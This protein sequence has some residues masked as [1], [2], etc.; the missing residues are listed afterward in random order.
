MGTLKVLFE[1]LTAR[2]EATNAPD[3]MEIL[4][5]LV[6]ALRLLL[7]IF[8]PLRVSLLY[9][10]LRRLSSGT[11]DSLLLALAVKNLFDTV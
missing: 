4:A 11:L 10:T 5:Y 2:F 3:W 1:A 8:G 6:V 7:P 9:V